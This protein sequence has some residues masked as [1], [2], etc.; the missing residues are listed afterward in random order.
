MKALLTSFIITFIATSS[1]ASGWIKKTD[2]GGIARHRTTGLGIGNKAYMGLGHYN[3]AGTNVLFDDWW[4]YDPAT[5]A[6]TQ[7]ADYMGGICYHATG[8]TLGDFGYVGTG[9][10]T[11]SGNT[12]VQ[13]FFKYDPT[14]NVWTPIS[15][16]PGTERRGAVSFV[17]NDYAYVGTGETNFGD[18]NDFYRYS[19][20]TDSWIAIASMPGI[21]R[22]SS[23]AFGIEGYGYVGTGNT[24]IGSTNDFWQYNPA[25]NSWIQKANVGPTNRQEASGFALNGRGYLGTGDDFS[26][27][28]NFKDMWEYDVSTNTWIQIEDFEGTARRYLTCVVLNGYAYAGMGT[29]GTNFKDFWLFNQTLSL[30]ERNL[31]QIGISAFPNPTT[32]FLTIDIQWVDGIPLENLEL[33][34][35]SLTGQEVHRE[36]LN[37]GTTTINTSSYQKGLYIYSVVYSDRHLKSGQVLIK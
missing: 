31:E 5:S 16:F 25:L 32:D 21:G 23:V 20:S 10:I 26:S 4:E 29:N 19:P 36:P 37:G 34:L 28:N 7:K 13:S 35:T 22:G 9:R 30:L 14:T 2:F 15:S 6:W 3:G 33:V 12:L 11:P 1:F 24:S 8:F 27:G 18:A 17:V